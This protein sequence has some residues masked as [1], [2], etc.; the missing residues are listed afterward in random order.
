MPKVRFRDIAR[1][2]C[3]AIAQDRR[4]NERSSVR[5][6]PFPKMSIDHKSEHLK[7]LIYHCWDILSRGG[8][9]RR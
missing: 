7:S 6:Q 3:T 2:P 5:D 9:C 8:G 4:P 1:V